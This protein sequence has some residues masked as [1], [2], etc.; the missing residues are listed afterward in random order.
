M[1]YNAT[2]SSCGTARQQ[3]GSAKPQASRGQAEDGPDTGNATM[4]S[5]HGWDDRGEH[6]H[7]VTMHRRLEAET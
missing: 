3:P 1:Q 6:G 4:R 7:K 2:A 5:W